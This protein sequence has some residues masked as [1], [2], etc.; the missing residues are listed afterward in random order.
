MLG[1]IALALSYGAYVAEV[2]RAGIS[3]STAA[4]A[5]PALA[6]G[7]TERQALRHVILPQAV[8]RVGP[9]LLNDFIALQKDVALIA[10]LGVTGEA[11]RDGADRGGRRLQLH[12][13]DRRGAALPRG[14][15]PAGAPARP[16]GH[17]GQAAT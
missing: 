6:I 1:G 10:I 12:A 14:H 2:Y 5:T 13:A 11:F 7:L 4:S 9:P 3:R 15:D 8:R 17:T 16:L